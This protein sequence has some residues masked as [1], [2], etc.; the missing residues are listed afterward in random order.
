MAKVRFWEASPHTGRK[1]LYDDPDK[2]RKDCLEYLAWCEDNPLQEEKIV[3][4]P[5]V[6]MSVSRMRAPTLQGLRGFIGMGK[7]AWADY[8]QKPLFSDV[9][10]EIEE[11]LYN[12][13]F[14][15]AAAGL[16]KDNIIARDLGL[17][18]KKQVEG[19]VKVEGIEMKFISPE[20][21]K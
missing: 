6:R 21:G 13:K 16:L 1:P 8:R 17:A 19:Q 3:G 4:S 11:I 12:G 2:L 9:I 7:S 15:G 20:G 5:P 10:E 14:A 18:D